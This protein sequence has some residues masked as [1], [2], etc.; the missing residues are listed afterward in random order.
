[1]NQ[2]VSIEKEENTDDSKGGEEGRQNAED[3]QKRGGKQRKIKRGFA[4]GKL[5]L[6]AFFKRQPFPGCEDH[7]DGDDQHRCQEE[8]RE[9]DAHEG[10][11]RNLKMRIEVEILRIAEGGEHTAEIGGDVLHDKDEGGVARVARVPQHV[12]AEREEGDQ[13]HVVSDQHRADEGDADERGD[14]RAQRLEDAH[15]AACQY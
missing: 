10:E 5:L 14:R 6:N 15:D 12:P 7:T 4:E 8:G 13:R 11:R 3:H 2:R 1:M 9:H